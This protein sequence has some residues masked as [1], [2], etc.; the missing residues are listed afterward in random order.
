MAKKPLSREDVNDTSPVTVRRGLLISYLTLA[1]E[2]PLLAR[3]AER[4]A[5]A[6]ALITSILDAPH[7]YRTDDRTRQV[8]RDIVGEEEDGEAD[9]GPA[10]GS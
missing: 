1:E 5:R 4:Y 3:Q 10:P 2:F 6:L 8:L 7:I 9:V